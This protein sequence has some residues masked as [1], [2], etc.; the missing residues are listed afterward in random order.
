VRVKDP[1]IALSQHRCRNHRRKKI[2]RTRF[3][4]FFLGGLVQDRIDL[5]DAA[6]RLLALLGRPVR[7]PYRRTSASSDCHSR[8]F[9]T[10]FAVAVQCAW[11]SPRRAARVQ[12]RAFCS[13]GWRAGS[14]A[15]RDAVFGFSR[16]GIHRSIGNRGT[17]GLAS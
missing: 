6:A 16:R 14:V 8:L 1:E 9:C 5:G 4:R 12:R 3:D 11:I 13:D 17:H 10:D 2:F 15:A 7:E